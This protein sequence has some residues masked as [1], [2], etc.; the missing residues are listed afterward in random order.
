MLNK[1]NYLEFKYE[2]Y[3][4]FFK[5]FKGFKINLVMFKRILVSIL[6]IVFQS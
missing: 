4:V 1:I 3:K 2:K 6:F 5:K